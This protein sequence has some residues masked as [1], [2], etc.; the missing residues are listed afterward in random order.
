MLID[1]AVHPEWRAKCK[2]E[3]QDLLSRHLDSSLS[4]ATLHEKLAAVPVSAWED[5][6]PIL[7]AC[8]RESQ[9]IVT[10][11]VTLRRN[12]RE[13]MKIGEQ[14]V[15]RGDFLAYSLAE[16][17]L[18]P[19]YY[20]EPYKYDPGRW[21]RPDPVPDAVYPFLGWGAG[22]HPCAGMKVAKLEMKLIMALFLTRYEFGLVDKDGK[23][24]N[25]L[26]VPNRNDIHQVRV[27]SWIVSI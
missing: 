2:K 8:A 26:P 18:N 17:H 23:F 4:S 15:K 27:E 21:L 25:P 16:V 19:E 13:E 9:R 24:P 20:P 1:L 22:R 14:V 12:I 11:G 7:E 10:S 5:E 3:I 6:L